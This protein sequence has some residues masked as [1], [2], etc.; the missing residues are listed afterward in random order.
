MR[1][2][3]ALAGIAALSGSIFAGSP[4][5]AG[6]APPNL[7][8]PLRPPANGPVRVGVVMGPN[9]V[10]IDM[11]GPWTAFGD[12]NIAGNGM[13]DR[14]ELYGIAP[15]AA[16]LD[17][18]GLMVSPQY[19]FANAP[20]PHVL[21]VPAQKSLP[22]TIAYLKRAALGADVTMSVCTGAFVAARAGLFDGLAATTH[23]GGYDVFAQMFPRVRLIRGVKYVENATVSSAGGET[24]GIDLALRVVERYYGADVA[25]SA[26]Y[27]MEYRRIARPQGPADV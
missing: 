3:N 4:A 26:A 23:H 27:N 10:A 5:E 18:D 6:A 8:K 20:Q 15:T 14:F 21:V 25:R 7:G 19:T 11:F 17:V 13:K 16:P 9:L 22:E 1:R 2:S 24:S 12:G